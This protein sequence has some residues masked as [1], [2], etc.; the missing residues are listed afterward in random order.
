[1]K[2]AALALVLLL[3]SG[4][5]AGS[6]QQ[7]LEGSAVSVSL[8]GA[9]SELQGPLGVVDVVGVDSGSMA[10][11]LKGSIRMEV[12][13][14]HFEGYGVTARATGSGTDRPEGT[15][16]SV[17]GTAGRDNREL[18]VFPLGG[19]PAHVLTGPATV[20]VA[21]PS[22]IAVH[23][24]SGVE[25]TPESVPAQGLRIAAPGVEVRGTFAVA[26]WEWDFDVV[27]SDGQQSSHWTGV[28]TAPVYGLPP[29]TTPAVR[30][31]DW[32]QAFLFVTDGVLSIPAEGKAVAYLPSGAADVHGTLTFQGVHAA[33]ATS[34][35]AQ[36]VS[37]DRF[38]I[39][40][41]LHVDLGAPVDG[42]VPF[43]AAGE[44]RP[45][46]EVDGATLEWTGRTGWWPAWGNWALVGLAA[47]A[48]PGSAVLARRGYHRWEDRRLEEAGELLELEA[49]EDAKACA[50]PLLRSRRYSG[51]AAVIHVEALLQDGHPAEARPLLE[52]ERLWRLAPAMRDYMT[53][54]VEA[55]LGNVDRAREA[56]HA[57]L[58]AAPDLSIQAREDLA[59]R[60]LAETL[61]EGYA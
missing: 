53:A 33:M 4:A 60:P 9:A 23:Q 10:F 15:F 61:V 59:L 47:L 2:A 34:S 40:G 8:A 5:Q 35:V 39:R 28:R 52:Q 58:A 25:R 37:A 22:S 57:A 54:R 51:E 12:D 19:A 18:V 3:A 7:V 1:M 50:R 17:D 48:A 16:A 32:Q 6:S 30:Q 26:L 43:Q 46:I 14:E 21:T 20:G 27:G 24:V 13:R 29:E 38:S 36:E 41:D 45:V 49:F 11:H 44:G 42:R 56:L 55:L 31:V